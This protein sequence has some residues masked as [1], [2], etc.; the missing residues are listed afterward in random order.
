MHTQRT[1]ILSFLKKSPFPKVKLTV[2]DLVSFLFRAESVAI[3]T[4][5]A[6]PVVPDL[7][8]ECLLVGRLPY[9]G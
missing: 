3:Y 5:L 8:H 1:L 4:V 6:G 9:E 2:S 7:S